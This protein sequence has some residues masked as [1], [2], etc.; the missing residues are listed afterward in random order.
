VLNYTSAICAHRDV[1]NRSS[2]MAQ[3]HSATW[4]LLILAV[5]YITIVV[6]VVYQN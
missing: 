1:T 2:H 4:Y 6:I 5:N 3:V